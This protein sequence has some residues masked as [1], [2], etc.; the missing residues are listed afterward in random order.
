MTDEKHADTGATQ[1]PMRVLVVDD[2]RDVCRIYSI[3]L[4]KS[5]CIV[6]TAGSGREALQ[7]LMQQSF[8]VL[9]VD[10]HMR[11]MDG[12]VFLEEALKIW[13]WLG[14]V[15]VSGD[16]TDD[17]ADRAESMGVRHILKKPADLKELYNAIRS[18]AADRAAEESD[19]PR[20]NALALMRDHLRLLTRLGQRAIGTETLLDALMEFGKALAGMLPAAVVGILVLEEDE[21]SLLLN[22]H[23]P[24]GPTFVAAVE[25]EMFDRHSALSGQKL[26]REAIQ[27]TV[28]GEECR[29]EG[30][31]GFG[32][33][34]SVPIILGEVVCGVLTLAT[35]ET[36]AY[37]PGDVSLLYHA[38]NH[39]SA[40]FMA[41]RKMHHLATRDPLT[42]VYNRIRLEEELERAWLM[43][44][45]YGYAMGV[46]VVDIDNFKTLNDSYGHSVGDEVLGDFARIMQDVAR[47]SDVIARYGGDEFIAI[48]PRA[49][50]ADAV[51]F[52]ERLLRSTRDHLFCPTT[53]G[54]NLT[55]SVGRSVSTNP[56]APATASVLLSQADRALYMAKRAGR[57]RIC[58]WPGKGVVG[59]AAAGLA[60]TEEGVPGLEPFEMANARVLVVDD[61]K[62]ILTL[63]E[64]MLK[65]EGYD[66]TAFD[67]A[68]GAIKEIVTHKDHYDVLLTDLSLPGK[69]GVEL[70]H[71]VGDLDDTIVKIVMTGYATVDNAV[72]SLREGAY[73]FIQK[74]I[75]HGQLLALVQRAVEYRGL[76]L[77]KARYQSHL[78]EMVRKRSGQLA[79]SLDEIRRSYDFTLEALVAML[80]AKEHHTGEHSTRGREF[81]IILAR[82]MGVTGEDM[83]ALAH[84]ALLHD[85]GKIGIPDSILLRPGSLLPDEWEVMKRHPEIGYKILCSSPFLKEAAEIVWQ[86]HERYDGSGYPRGLRGD[87]ICLGARVFAVIDSYDAMR[88]VR[89]YRESVSQDEAVA[90]VRRCSGKEFDPDVVKAF[91]QCYHELESQ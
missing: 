59:A 84:G 91:L 6:E 13:P 11:A 79:S 42:G 2:E 37:R 17:A 80:D 57:N 4:R 71:E 9:V 29:P 24:V 20:G 33:T 66:V 16:V 87:E 60:V 61:E 10:L 68:V 83:E 72:N 48:L 8:D 81:A 40:V 65:R 49:D 73:D 53:Y 28:E 1:A 90:E 27:I 7:I 85:I 19:I 77:E 23:D 46:V 50:E 44:N 62:P 52:G 22:V 86:H 5:G 89:V 26:D 32:S 58:I 51:T 38:A 18:A 74:P 31:P 39:I 55:I 54:L 82:Q 76:R 47:A 25:K 56:T 78:E 69:S 75:A 63:V 64:M 12:I 67:S 88:S 15:I 34:L 45:R 36:D 43:A 14:T 21:K 41:L 70:L 35:V 30:P 3:G